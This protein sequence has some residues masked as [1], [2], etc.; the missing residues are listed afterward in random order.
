MIN[1]STGP[2]L[3]QKIH[4]LSRTGT[5]AYKSKGGGL[6]QEGAYSKDACVLE[7]W[8]SGGSKPKK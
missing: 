1:V 6:F 5:L 2:Q 8:P 7:L 4:S 3:R